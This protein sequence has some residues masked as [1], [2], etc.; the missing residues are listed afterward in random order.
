MAVAS[1]IYTEISEWALQQRDHEAA[2][3]QPAPLSP[4]QRKALQD[5]H[6][7]IRPSQIEPDIGGIDWVSLLHRYRNAYPDPNS[8]V[9]FKEEPVVPS[10]P[11]RFTCSVQIKEN[12]APFPGP[13]TGL[14]NDAVPSFARKKDAKQYAAKCAIE[15]LKMKKFIPDNTEDMTFKKPKA[16]STNSN[17]PTMT[18]TTPA[19]SQQQPAAKKQR[20]IPP[21][22]P[23]ARVMTQNPMGLGDGANGNKPFSNGGELSALSL[24]EQ[25][26]KKLG[27][28]A[29]RYNLAE[30]EIR[31]F[32]CG[33]PEFEVVD[34]Q[35]LKFPPDMGH[36]KDILGKKHAKELMADEVLRHLQRVYDERQ[37]TIR[38]VLANLGANS[39]IGQNVG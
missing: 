15:W 28:Q 12:S 7:A 14:I 21:T 30:Q 16:S 25:Y 38:R 2:H 17:I 8:G 37:E 33:S 18:T 39:S 11:P 29:P 6:N 9:I 13:G 4:A 36:V 23:E 34:T 20:R 26:C 32:W 5:L 19:T 3:G 27:I 1:S 35:R 10:A 24:V 31:G 22:P